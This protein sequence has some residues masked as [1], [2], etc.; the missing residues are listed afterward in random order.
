MATSDP[1]Q[2]KL[3]YS[4]TSAHEDWTLASD[5]ETMPESNPHR[6]RTQLVEQQLRGW[7]AR[8]GRPVQVGGNLAI[9]WDEEHP[10][11]GVDPDVYVVEPPPPEG[12]E[13]KSLRLWKPGHHAPLL[14]VEIVS[15]SEPRKDYVVAPEKYAAS[16]TTELWVFDP[17]LAG[18]RARGGPFRLQMWRRGAEGELERV[19][20]G[21]GPMRSAALDAWVFAVDEGRALRIA[22]DEA[23]TSWWATPLE[24][25]RAAKEAERA[26][27]EAAL[28]AADTERAAKEAALFTAEAERAAKEAALARVAELERALGRRGDD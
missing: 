14:A 6:E 8:C 13:V 16:G 5:D 7:A 25:E 15:G 10:G 4:V 18:P 9:R 26:A 28:A 1:R 3:R 20:A 19:Y 12:Y 24:A 2:V 27:K 11:F 17:E 21:A 23:G 22:D